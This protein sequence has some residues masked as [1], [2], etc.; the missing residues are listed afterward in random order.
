MPALQASWSISD[1]RSAMPGHA[2]L[3]NT[4][5][6]RALR[7]ERF[8]ADETSASPDILPAVEVWVNTGERECIRGTCVSRSTAQ[9]KPQPR[10]VVVSPGPSRPVGRLPS[11]IVRL[12]TH[13]PSV[14]DRRH[15]SVLVGSELSATPWAELRSVLDHADRDTFDVRNLGAAKT[16]RVAA[17]CLLLLWSIG[18][19]CR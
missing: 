19:P 1:L 9:S 7:R 8:E 14:I 16:K 12:D 2:D 4:V 18:M 3:A 15:G 17:A 10:S 13:R 6:N 5:A 11:R